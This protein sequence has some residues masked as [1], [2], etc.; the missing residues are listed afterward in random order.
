MNPG[1][2]WKP[3]L[4][5][6]YLLEYYEYEAET[7]T[8]CTSGIYPRPMKGLALDP[9]PISIYRE[10]TKTICFSILGFFR[11]GVKLGFNFLGV[12]PNQKS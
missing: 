9:S 1:R 2:A 3:D 7:W 6:S 4:E 8:L 10:S 12:S 11:P 5:E